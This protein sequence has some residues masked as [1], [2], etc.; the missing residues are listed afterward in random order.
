MQIMLGN[1]KCLSRDFNMAIKTICDIKL[2]MNDH[3]DLTRYRYENIKSS[4][5]TKVNQHKLSSNMTRTIN[6]IN[7]S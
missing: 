7:E 1:T 3:K 2:Y 5:Q 4:H 6:A